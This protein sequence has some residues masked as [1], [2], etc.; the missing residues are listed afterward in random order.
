M[1]KLFNPFL[2]ATICGIFLII[3][4]SCSPN[5]TIENNTISESMLRAAQSPGIPHLLTSLPS[6]AMG[7]TIGPGGDLFVT[8]SGLEGKILRIDKKTGNVSTFASGLPT[9]PVP[10]GGVIDVAFIDDTAYAL[11][12]LVSPVE[13]FGTNYANGIY[14]IDGP[15]S[16]TLIADIGQFA[17]D[18]Q[19]TGFDFFLPTGLQFALEFYKGA[20][21]VT[22]GHHNRIY[23]VTLEGDVSEFQQFDNIVPTGIAI[24]GNNVY[25]SETGTTEQAYDNS[26]IISIDSKTLESSQV[27]SGVPFLVDVE[28]NR[29]R[30]LFAISQGIWAGGS[31]G[32][33]ALPNTGS[34]ARVNNDG[35]LTVIASELNLPTSLEFIQNTAYVVSLTG[36]IWTIDN[37]G[38]PPYGTSN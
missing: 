11:V 35:T 8:Q 7:S 9:S 3:N 25:I 32:D 17:L 33:A 34:L 14:R 13:F 12:T 2:V 22:D 19:P 26:R 27:A 30:S 4:I 24:S 5:E 36:Q 31:D 1:K 29:G 16:Y 6:I 28:F 21:L 10:I 23:H 38:E 15:D 37:V 20:F 18:N